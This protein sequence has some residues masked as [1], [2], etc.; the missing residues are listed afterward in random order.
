MEMTFYL[1][2]NFFASVVDIGQSGFEIYLSFSFY[3][4]SVLLLPKRQYKFGGKSKMKETSANVNQE[5][6]VRKYFLSEFSYDDGEYEITFN[7]VDIDFYRQTI[8]NTV[9]KNI[10]MENIV[11][12]G[13]KMY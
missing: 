6:E 2:A 7:I 5:N 3:P 11:L 9:H 13:E 12:W 10:F 1:Y 8:K 4:C